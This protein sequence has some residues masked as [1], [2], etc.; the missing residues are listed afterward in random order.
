MIVLSVI[1]L[2]VILIFANLA[3]SLFNHIYPPCESSL[4]Y[5]KSARLLPNGI[6]A[7]LETVHNSKSNKNDKKHNEYYI[8]DV[9]GLD[10]DGEDKEKNRTKGVEMYNVIG[11]ILK[12][13]RPELSNTE[14]EDSSFSN[15]YQAEFE[16]EMQGIEQ[17]SH[18]RKRSS[19]KQT[20]K[21]SI[22]R[23]GY[24]DR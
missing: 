22:E 15:N 17:S 23:D 12:N 10:K 1:I 24:S 2:L 20:A 21:D 9:I 11:D 16:S 14:K 19:N 4:D 7:G 8:P 13:K 3:I 5:F 18:Q 6:T